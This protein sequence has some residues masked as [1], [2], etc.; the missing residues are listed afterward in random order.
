M[1]INIATF[2]LTGY[3]VPPIMPSSI[4]RAFSIIVI[5]LS[6]AIEVWSKFDETSIGRKKAFNKRLTSIKGW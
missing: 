3:K 2:V 5:P 4:A 1:N 6:E